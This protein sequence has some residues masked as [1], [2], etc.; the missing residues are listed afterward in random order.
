M[1]GA[2]VGFGSQL[3]GSGIV[4]KFVPSFS[5]WT[6][7]GLDKYDMVKA[8][9]VTRRAFAR[10]D[11]QWSETDESLMRYVASIAPSVEGTK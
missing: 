11:R 7:K 4:P 6:D 1:A 5:F 3:S 10:H 8:A 9:E 2:Y